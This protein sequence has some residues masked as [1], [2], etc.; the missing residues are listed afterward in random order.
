MTSGSAA[1]TAHTRR[2]G[3]S[4]RAVSHASGTAIATEAAVTTA[5]RATLRASTASVL[6][7]SATSRNSPQPFSSDLK[8]KYTSGRV[9]AAATRRAGAHTAA[10]GRGDRA[11]VSERGF[12]PAA[13]K[14]QYPR[15]PEQLERTFQ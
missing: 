5:A 10:G 15:L 2:P 4:V 8:T 12:L 9:I 6:S 14:L 3:R 13:I 1:S 7:R 11:L